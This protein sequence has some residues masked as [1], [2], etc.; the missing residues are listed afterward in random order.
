MVEGKVP[1]WGALTM[2]DHARTGTRQVDPFISVSRDRNRQRAADMA[3]EREKAQYLAERD[4]DRES[5]ATR[6]FESGRKQ[7]P[8]DFPGQRSSS[9]RER[10]VQDARNHT[11]GKRRHRPNA[12][13]DDEDDSIR[14]QS[15]SEQ[16]YSS[17]QPNSA[18][19]KQEQ[20]QRPPAYAAHRDKLARQSQARRDSYDSVCEGKPRGAAEEHEADKRGPHAARPGHYA[21]FTNDPPPIFTPSESTAKDVPSMLIEPVLPLQTT[22]PTD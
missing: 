2:E 16:G 15:A 8:N 11:G 4:R 14:S 9:H 12:S 17:R 20:N 21:N 13:S 18:H 5:R 19:R 6:Y 3:A 22:K 10:R 1:G 7:Q